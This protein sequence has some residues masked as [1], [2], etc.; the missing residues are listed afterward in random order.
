M[1]L[2]DLQKMFGISAEQNLEYLNA[3]KLDEEAKALS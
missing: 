2:T 1:L 3:V